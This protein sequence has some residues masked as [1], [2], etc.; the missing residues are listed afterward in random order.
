MIVLIK[1][2]LPG[3]HWRYRPFFLKYLY[4]AW[5]WVWRGEAPIAPSIFVRPLLN[6]FLKE[7]FARRLRR[8]R[9]EIALRDGL[10]DATRSTL[11]TR[12]DSALE[13]W[14]PPRYAALFFS[15]VVPTMPAIF[16]LSDKLTDLVERLGSRLPISDLSPG[17]LIVFGW[18]AVAYVIAIPATAFLAKR[19]LFLG[20]D[21][22]WF[23]GWQDGNGAYQKEKQIFG[24]VE[25]RVREAPLDL[26]IL[27]ILT[28]I[29]WVVAYLTW[30][31]INT[32]SQSWLS[33]PQSP[34]QVRTQKIEDIVQ[35]VIFAV[36]FVIAAVRR[37]K[38]GRA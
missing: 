3:E 10:T 31:Q 24:S 32:W 4:Y 30:D 17:A 19:G 28:V 12:L 13:R 23:P 18:S 20:A 34:R 15:F 26:W 38:L 5:V 9:E 14:N 27:S 29:S 22:I 7:H 8:L 21:R 6:I 35:S 1:N 33:Q 2:L 37:A 36:G 16:W 25:I 11:I